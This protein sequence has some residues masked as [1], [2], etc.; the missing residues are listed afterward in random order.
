MELPKNLLE[1]IAFITRPKIENH[2][3]ILMD[4]S[5]HEE[6]LSQPL[7]IEIK[8]FKKAV[9]FLTAYNGTLNVTN[10]NN[11]LYFNKTITNEDRFINITIS[12]GA[13]E[14]EILKNEI[15]R[16]IIDQEPFTEANYPFTIKPIFST[17][18]SIIEISQQR[19]IIS[20]M[21]DESIRD[22]L[23][24]NARTFY[25]EYS[26]S[27]NSVDI[28][29]FDNVFFECN[30]AQ[31]MIFRGKRYGVSHN[32]TMD[33]DP[34]YKYIEKFRGGV[35]SYILESKDNISSICF[36]LKNENNQLVS[37]SGQSIT[38]R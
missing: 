2:I 3:L 37:F 7:Q 36:K 18:G 30:F 9:T 13:Y 23:G 14:I 34:G 6:H 11:K 35:Q 21:F 26:P 19:P 4:K 1:K 12:P 20:F 16:S 33:V 22:L 28:L 31:G 29:S 24:F 25:E 8:Q 5:T 32:F 10:E 15:Q 17:L 27:K 38:F